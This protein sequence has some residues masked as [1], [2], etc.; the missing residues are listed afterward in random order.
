M[1]VYAFGIFI[2]STSFHSNILDIK[3]IVVIFIDHLF[4]L[5]YLI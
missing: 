5:L 2:D 3:Y 1:V 4:L